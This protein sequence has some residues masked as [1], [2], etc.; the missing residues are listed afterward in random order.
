[1]GDD[2]QWLPLFLNQSRIKTW[3]VPLAGAMAGATG[4]PPPLMDIQA[5]EDM[6]L[7]FP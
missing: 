4:N 5:C 1:M 6:P 7:C 3:L 2:S